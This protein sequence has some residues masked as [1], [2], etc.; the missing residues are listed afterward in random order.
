MKTP[1]STAALAIVIVGILVLQPSTTTARQSCW[2]LQQY[3][4]CDLVFVPCDDPKNC[5]DCCPEFLD[6][7]QSDTANKLTCCHTFG[8]QDGVQT[9]TSTKRCKYWAPECVFEVGMRQYVC[10]HFDLK[11]ITCQSEAIN[12]KGAIL[13]PVPP[14]G[15]D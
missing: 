7:P 15:G 4:C 14:G 3:S 9:T 13:C 6:P 11:T 8:Y 12:S 10:Y 2:T 5:E 1:L